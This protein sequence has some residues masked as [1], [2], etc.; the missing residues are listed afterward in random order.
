[1]LNLP[2][3]HHTAISEPLHGIMRSCLALQMHQQT[4]AW[5]V[6]PVIPMPELQ[7]LVGFDV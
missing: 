1:M 6:I 5:L 2:W 3:L 7:S 4:P